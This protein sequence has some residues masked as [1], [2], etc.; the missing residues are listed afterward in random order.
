MEKNNN[1]EVIHIADECFAIPVGEEADAFHGMIGLTEPTA[2]LLEKMEKPCSVN[3]LIDL[4]TNEYEVTRDKA[5]EDVEKIIDA[6]IE[7]R[8]VLR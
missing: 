3:D 6:L 8:L 7:Y 1:Y 5:K 2:F 4:L